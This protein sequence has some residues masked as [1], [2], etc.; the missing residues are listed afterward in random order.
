MKSSVL[1]VRMD[2]ELK[3][4][5]EKLYAELG[6]SLP[7]AVRMFIAQSVREQALPIRL[8]K[9]D[10]SFGALSKYADPAKIAQ[11]ADAWHSV[12]EEK[13]HAS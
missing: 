7:E 5:A 8:A 11:E 9:T 4:A 2:G 12:A 6:T 13:H 3:A 10:A 1:Q